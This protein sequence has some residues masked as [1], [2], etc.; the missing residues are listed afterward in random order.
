MRLS[1]PRLLTTLRAAVLGAAALLAAA[2]SSPAG[3]DRANGECPPE[4]E[5]SPDTPNGLYFGAAPLGDQMFTGSVVTPHRVAVGGVETVRLFLDRDAQQSF[6][7]P[8]R[9][10]PA[11]PAFTVQGIAGASVAIK[12]AAPGTAYLRIVETDADLLYDR[13]EL[14]ANAVSGVDLVHGPEYAYADKGLE[15]LPPPPVK[16]H[17]AG[18]TR[19]VLRLVDDDGA[20]L[21]DE[22][23][24]IDDPNL[25]ADLSRWDV[26]R[27]GPGL[28]VGPVQLDVLLGDGTS[29]TVAFETT[30]KV[31]AVTWTAGFDDRPPET[32][33]A[34]DE[35][36][37]F[38]FRASD[39]SA[40]VLG[41]TFEFQA[42]AELTLSP[43][44]DAPSC[45]QVKRTATGL[46]TLTV[47]AG[48]AE[49]SF[50][51]PTNAMPMPKPAPRARP[52]AGGPAPGERLLGVSASVW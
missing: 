51:I 25:Q 28:P 39:G 50:Q 41:A 49:A 40:V 42:S 9:A 36:V 11:G 8:Y 43:G 4:E 2:S 45:V 7:R 19:L 15:Q 13:Y 30:D 26:Y 29:K 10:L 23:A 16:Y 34:L 37:I 21:V 47:N 44:L 52:A 20:R 27:I 31:T 24:V 18:D 5:C 17:V 22:T 46:A 32:G 38:C 48:G 14:E 6:N 35:Q 3:G 33:L 12:G 1:S